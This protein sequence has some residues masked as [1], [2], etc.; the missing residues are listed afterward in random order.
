MKNNINNTNTPV[1]LQ[2]ALIPVCKMVIRF[3]L[4]F[5]EF[6]RNLQRAY[7]HAAEE[8]LTSANIEPNLQAIA[9]KTGMDRRTIAEHKKN[10]NKPYADPMNKMD[11]LIVQLQLYC[12]KKESKLLSVKRLQT[13][14]DAIYARHIRSNAIIRELLS[15]KI[16]KPINTNTYKL[17][18]TLQQQLTDIRLMA[19]DVDFTAKRLFQTYYKNMFEAQESDNLELLQKTSLST[20]I[21]PSKH[22]KVI[23][24]LS[25][26]LKQSEIKM[27]KIIAQHEANIPDGTYP[28]LGITLFQFSSTKQ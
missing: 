24:L 8:I 27:K 9:I 15:N 12:G 6:V 23:G 14:I 2:A 1:Q 22:R 3:G 13:I 16:I 19:D 20:K 17:N 7:I 18:L 5:S 26:E 10:I 28:E 25:E 21:A 4:H 11:M